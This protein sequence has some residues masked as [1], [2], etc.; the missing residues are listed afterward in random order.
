MNNHVE[1]FQAPPVPWSLEIARVFC[2]YVATCGI[3]KIHCSRRLFAETSR[4]VPESDG[5]K[6]WRT[7]GRSRR[8]FQYWESHGQEYQGFVDRKEK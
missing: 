7:E 6:G 3:W 2:L 5:S 1:P 8:R 4:T